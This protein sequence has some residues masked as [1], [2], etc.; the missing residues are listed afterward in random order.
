MDCFSIFIGSTSR[1]KWKLHLDQQH[2]LRRRQPAAKAAGAE[3]DGFRWC[4]SFGSVESMR[5]LVPV[6]TRIFPGFRQA[7]PVALQLD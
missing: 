2:I 4:H 7:N 6:L 1:C 5:L 3:Q